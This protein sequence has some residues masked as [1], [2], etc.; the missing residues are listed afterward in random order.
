M[1]FLRSY[2]VSYV[3]LGEHSHSHYI[4][5]KPRCRENDFFPTAPLFPLPHPLRERSPLSQGLG[6]TPQQ[7]RI[8]GYHVKYA[9]P[10]LK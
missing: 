10:G 6:P 5:T 1:L 4:G 3:G 7:W 9:S 8:K 2:R